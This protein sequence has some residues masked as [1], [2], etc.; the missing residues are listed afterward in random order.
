MG[1]IGRMGRTSPIASH[2]SHKTVAPDY[3][4]N[5]LDRY[6]EFETTINS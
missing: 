5:K 6:H 1:L 3:D 2:L 4:F